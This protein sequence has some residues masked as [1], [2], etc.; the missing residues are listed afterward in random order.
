MI[1]NSKDWLVHKAK[2]RDPD[3]F[4]ELM[5]TYTKDMYKVAISILMNDEDA[6][7][8]IQETILTCWEKIEMLKY[9]QYFK[10]WLIRI[11]INNCYDIRKVR[12]KI[13]TMEGFEEPS[14]EDA[15]NLELKEALSKLDEKYRIVM[16]LFYAEGY[17]IREIAK[18][19]NIS[20][21]TVQTRLDRGRKKLKDYYTAN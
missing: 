7:D 4:T 1:Q 3:A 19:L 2:S 14:A 10:T 12:E 17:R 15:Y 13:I 16:M 8:A 9:N 11:L 21:S 5:Q 6:A 20:Q 18:L